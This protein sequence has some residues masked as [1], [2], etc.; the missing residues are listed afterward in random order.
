MFKVVLGIPK[1]KEYYYEKIKEKKEGTIS[2]TDETLFKKVLKTLDLLRNNPRHPGLKTH[3][4]K[5]LSKKQGYK[6]FQSYLENKKSKAWRIL[7]AYGPQKS[8]I[9]ILSIYPHPDDKKASYD[10]IDISSFPEV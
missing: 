5:N 8:Y 9:T 4:L 7:W 10:D 3:E 6:V 2:K 1:V